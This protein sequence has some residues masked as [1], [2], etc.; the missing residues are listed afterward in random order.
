MGTLVP[1]ERP[2]KQTKKR[3]QANRLRICYRFKTCM[4]HVSDWLFVKTSQTGFG[5][6]ISCI[7]HVHYPTAKPVF[8]NS[9]NHM[10]GL[11]V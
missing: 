2:D 11:V 1:E 5:P 6:Y 10:R 3:L 4:N 7:I 9:Q 8:T